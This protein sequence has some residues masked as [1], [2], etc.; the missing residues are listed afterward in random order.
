M[1][2]LSSASS[3]VALGL[4]A[5]FS[6]AGALAQQAADQ[7]VTEQ[8]LERIEVTG[9]A[10][11]RVDTETPSPVQVI[12]A[13][14]IKRSGQTN[15]SEILR[16]IASNG[17][18]TLSQSFGQAFAGGASG[19]ALRGLNLGSTL[20]LIDGHRIA[21]Y[22]L[23]DDGQRSFTD[24]SSIPFDAVERIEV[25]KDGASALYGSDAIAG[26]VNIILKKQFTGLN[27]TA[28]Q[29]VSQRGDGAQTHLTA[30]AGI[31]DLGADGYNLFGSV[32]FRHQANIQV[33][34]RS[35]AWTNYN[36]SGF[37]NGFNDTPGAPILP[38]AG[39]F[40]ATPLTTNGLIFNPSNPSQYA[41]LPGNPTCQ[42]D[43]NFQAGGCAFNWNGLEIQPDDTN[44]N[45]LVRF[46][47]ALTAGWKNS[48]EV[49][50]FSNRSEQVGPGYAA[51]SA[52]G[53]SIGQNS[54]T[55]I[56]FSPSNPIPAIVNLPAITVPANYPGNPYGAPANIS[57]VYTG[58]GLNVTTFTTTTKRVVDDVTGN[59]AG[60]DLGASAGYTKAV[61]KER[62]SGYI[63]PNLLQTALNN[64]FVLNSGVGDPF[65]SFAPDMTASPSDE[66]DFFSLSASR[67][68]LQLPGGALGFAV[69]G[70]Y[71]HRNL[72]ATAPANI[73]N[74]VTPG[75][76]AFAVGQQNIG[77]AYLELNAPVAKWAEINGEARYDHY[78]TYG[79]STT[80]KVGFKLTPISQLSVRGTWGRGFRAPNP[81]ESGNGGQ[82]YQAAS[83][84]DPILCPNPGTPTAAGN[85]PSQCVLLPAG[86]NAS[87]PKL[88]PEKSTNKT[89]GFV[90]EPS[91]SLNLSVDW[92][93]IKVNNQIQG[94]GFVGTI[95]SAG[96]LVQAN[97]VR[98]PSVTLPYCSSAGNCTTSVQTGSIYGVGPIGFIS[99]PYINATLTDTSGIDFDLRGTLN[100]NEAGR[101]LASVSATHVIKYNITVAG[102]T[103]Y[104]A[105][106]HGPSYFS[107]DTGNPRNRA[108]VALTWDKKP[109]ELT[110]TMNYVGG[111]SIT[112]PVFS[113]EDQC[114]GAAV[115][116]GTSTYGVHF[117][118]TPPSNLCRV[119]SF[120]D[121][122]LSA[123]YALDKNWSLHGSIL[124]LL[125]TS[126]PIDIV[127][128]GG[129]GGLPY[130]AALHQAGAVG[131]YFIAGVTYQ[132]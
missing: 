124:N 33:A 42:S 28:E 92:Y 39:S 108:V 71:D 23:S 57:M 58:M 55:L 17:Q 110:L 64:G 91:K 76:D 6:G 113:G 123:R 74:G 35:G 60:W 128:Y 70:E 119:A 78:D 13:E 96:G 121:F 93:D 126:P 104:E 109:L 34:N 114:T 15:I 125:D 80:P 63:Q 44:V 85:F 65:G 122:D 54:I 68:L 11:R 12:T 4:A 111:I 116:N 130:N 77:A 67:D 56:N 97:V 106:T 105:G 82:A 46:T 117:Y 5:A 90:L 32:E 10:I 89:F 3:A 127:T 102:N 115:S 8:Q 112:D 107:G 37:Q 83:T 84:N 129:G 50:Q 81:A 21:P 59:V 48:L 53:H 98:G 61:T 120:T 7:V 131:R 41:Y 26:V 20:V 30:T 2:R 118:G 14:D 24:I 72:D 66:L 79:S 99:T 40:T 47:K 100:L 51:S 49:S 101:L 73:A 103:F 43:A 1:K 25:L 38:G 36:W 18:G 75:N 88:L 29:G 16:D 45:L 69:G 94:A 87:N 95:P 62:F 22:P 27:M 19:V 86:V 31:G 52:F 132:F 9:T